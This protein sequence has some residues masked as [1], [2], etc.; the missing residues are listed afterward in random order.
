MPLHEQA[1]AYLERVA[2][3]GLPRLE[4]LDPEQARA[5]FEAA[6]AAVCGPPEPVAE[7]L[8]RTVPGPAGAVRVRVYRPDLPGPLPVLAYFHGGGWVLG[9]LNTHDVLCRALA[10]RAGCVLVAVDYRLAP[11]H[12]FPAA[13]DDAWAAVEWLAG[14]PSEVG[15]GSGPLAVAGES[16]GG[17]LAAVVALRARDRGLDLALQVLVY[18][19]T[20]HNLDTASY[21][22]NAD[23]YGLTREG[24]RWFWSHYLGDPAQGSDPEAS[25]LRAP[26]LSGVAP[27]MIVTCDY[28]PLVDEGE[29]YAERLRQD[30]VPVR[31]RRFEGQI[32][33]F[34]RMLAMFDAASVAV[35]EVGVALREAWAPSL[36]PLPADARAPHPYVA[37]A[38][39]APPAGPETRPRRE[40]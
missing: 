5:G 24:M 22:A 33:G 16:A 4:T 23:G 18:P 14:H 38:E 6:S 26:D 29:A 12:R 40:G 39:A 1:R 34:F 31:L 11:E 20:D 30:G 7:C 27:A 36:S 2:A 21:R 17:N 35:A 13:V 8:D 15:G 25:P 28:D 32:H 19:V 3:L 37:P 9:N 10:N